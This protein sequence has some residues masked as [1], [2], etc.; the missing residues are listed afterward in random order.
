MADVSIVMPVFNGEAYLKESIES[1]LKQTYTD[2]EFIIVNDGSTDDSLRIIKD[3]AK[4]DRRIVLIS[5]ENKGLVASLNE[6]ISQASSKYIARMDADD[7]SHPDRIEKQLQ[8]FKENSVD[9]LGTCVEVFGDVDEKSRLFNEKKLNIPFGA[10]NA[11]ELILTHWY[12]L[13]HPSIMMKRE[14]FFTLNGYK[15]AYA[16]DLELWLRAL[17]NGFR[18]YKMPEKLLKYRLHEQ[19]KTNR[20]NE[21]DY[22]GIRDAIRLKLDYIL[23]ENKKTT[24][25]YLIWG[26]GNGGKITEEVIK[27]YYP[28]LKL[29][30]FIDKFRTGKYNG[31]PIYGL[32]Y[33][34]QT[35]YIF[36]ATEPGKEEAMAFLTKKGLKNIENFLC[37][38]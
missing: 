37:T 26:T 32:S 9:I 28:N 2:F 36:I 34:P 20:D 24:L 11:E 8:F 12:C 17:N 21:K 1:I 25:T 6:G 30:G 14:V 38:I 35:D 5:R 3:Y 19:S 27:E 13:A 29:A 7:I 18:I 15:N 16:E 10:D 22:R 33:Q 23:G 4:N 31:V